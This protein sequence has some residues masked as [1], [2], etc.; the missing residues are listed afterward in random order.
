M[1]HPTFFMYVDPDV[2]RR[3]VD[4]AFNTLY[5]SRSKAVVTYGLVV[6]LQ[7][8]LRGLIKTC[9]AWGGG[10]TFDSLYVGWILA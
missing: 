2:L 9:Y 5:V 10:S 4:G 6:H 8:S 7:L 3:A 1:F